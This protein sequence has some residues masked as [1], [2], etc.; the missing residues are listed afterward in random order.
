[1][2]MNNHGV[3]LGKEEVEYIRAQ[4]PQATVQQILDILLE[5]DR[6]SGFGITRVTLP[7]N[8]SDPVKVEVENPAITGT[9]GAA[10]TLTF[11]YWAGALSSLLGREFE[12]D[13]P[14]YDQ[15]SSQLKG[16]LIAR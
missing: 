3:R 12:V 4:N 10:K 1:V 11:S 8:N 5:S 7:V 16:T 9:E 13:D 15:D 6:I 14:T 2:I